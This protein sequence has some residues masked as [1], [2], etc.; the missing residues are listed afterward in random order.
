MKSEKT[1]IL[2]AILNSAHDGKLM[3]KEPFLIVKHPKDDPKQPEKI[4]KHAAHSLKNPDDIAKLVNETQRHIIIAGIS[5]YE[6]KDIVPLVDALVRSNRNVVASGLNLDARG[7]P[8][9]HMPGLMSLADDV[10]LTKAICN[11]NGCYREDAI[12]SVEVDEGVFE[13]RCLH[14]FNYSG[15]PGTTQD[16]E[17]AIVVFAGPMFASK[18]EKWSAIINRK[19]VSHVPYI[20]LTWIDNERYGTNSGKRYVFDEGEA[21]LNNGKRIAAVLVRNA[22]DV[23]EYLKRKPGV[24]DVF[25]D[26]VMLLDIDYANDKTDKNMLSVLNSYSAKGYRFYLT[27][28]NRNFKR[29]PFIEMPKLMCLATHIEMSNAYCVTCGH[30]S[31][32]NQRMKLIAKGKYVP[33]RYNDPIVATG[34]AKKKDEEPLQYYEARCLAHFELPDAPKPKYEFPK[35]P[36]FAENS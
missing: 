16:K 28:L 21:T 1:T 29:E 15:S 14:H 30:P 11:D 10:I 9:N 19:K 34:G 12:R 31:T 23:V 8:Y 36:P 32:E 25:I 27:G 26:E 2:E 4:G 5:H 35:W 20:T 6:S 33:A 13:P 3:E 18:S 17:G 7:H 22:D 24:R